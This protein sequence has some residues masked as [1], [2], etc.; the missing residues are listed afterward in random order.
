MTTTVVFV[1]KDRCTGCGDCVAAC[2]RDA[3]YLEDGKAHV[4]ASRCIGCEVCVD[5]CPEGALYTVSEPAV[6]AEAS[7]ATVPV[8]QAERALQ[9]RPAWVTGL[10]VAI[11]AA[12]RILPA[13]VNLIGALQAPDAEVPQTDVANIASGRDGGRGR[14]SRRRLRNRRGRRS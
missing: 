7:K 14:G 1:D 6:P 12:Q 10:G 2:P 9:S 4:R 5:A 13:V 11:M 3:I 8:E